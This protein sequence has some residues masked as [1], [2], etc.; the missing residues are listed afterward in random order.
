[1]TPL[2]EARGLV[3]GHGGTPVLGGV[4]LR[5]A[6]HERWVVLGPNGAGKSTLVRTL[7]GLQ[8]PL[9]GEVR[10]AGRPLA[11]WDRRELA[12]TVAWVPQRFEPPE[13]FTGLE[14]VLM[15][16]SPHLGLLG[17][18]SE[19]DVERARAVL[20]ELDALHLADRPASHLSG[21]EQR[22][23]LL[24]RA[25]VQEPSLLLLDEPTAFLDLRHQ[26]S[27]LER[28]R[29]RSA[30]GLTAV[31]VLHDVNLAHLFATHVL[32]VRDGRVLASGEAGEVLRE[33]TLSA[34]YG[35]PMVS[36]R[37]SEG[38]PLFA[39]RNGR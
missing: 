28:V 30:D 21:G 7:L 5:V 14:L 26:V 15:G 1:V 10:I 22:L 2:L 18:P 39:P 37:T 19:R 35:V 23:L 4:D 3:A 16:R 20:A 12:R 34:L 31:A 24:A 11:G 8:P 29:A 33:D 6:P 17:L 13:G 27:T 32:L 36:A 38:M 25:L 9:G